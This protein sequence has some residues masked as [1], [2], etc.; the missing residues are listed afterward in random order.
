MIMDEQ[1]VFLRRGVL[2]EHL[3]VVLDRI[4]HKYAGSHGGVYSDYGPPSDAPWSARGV[5]LYYVFAPDEESAAKPQSFF[6]NK[7]CA[8]YVRNS[9][10]YHV[11]NN[12]EDVAAAAE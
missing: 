12:H 11:W 3:N 1:E 7:T 4:G 8:V 9:R 6:R 5:P 2:A 10:K